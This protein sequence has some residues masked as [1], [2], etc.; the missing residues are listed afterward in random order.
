MIDTIKT[1]DRDLGVRFRAGD[2]LSFYLSHPAHL[3]IIFENIRCDS[4]DELSDAECTAEL[5]RLCEP[6]VRHY[7]DCL[8]ALCR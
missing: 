8:C 1:T 4:D 3:S 5:K 6:S 7:Y 2:D